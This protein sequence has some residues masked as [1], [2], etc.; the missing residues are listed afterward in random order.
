[1]RIGISASRETGRVQANARRPRELSDRGGSRPSSRWGG[2]GRAA[3][4]AATV[5]FA[6]S[7]SA[8]AGGTPAT[9]AG[10]LGARQ[11]LMPAGSTGTTSSGEFITNNQPGNPTPPGVP[12]NKWYSFFVEVPP[13]TARLRVQLFDPDHGSTNDVGTATTRYTLFDPSG[14]QQATALSTDAGP[15]AAN[16]AWWTL[17]DLAPA[18]YLLDQFTTVAYGNNNGPV[19]F[20]TNWIETSDDAAAATGGIFV[21]TGELRFGALP[22][23][24]FLDQFGVQAY[25]NSNGT[26][27]WAP[28]W[29]EANDGGTGATAGMIQV[30]SPGGQ[31][32]IRNGLFQDLFSTQVYT[33]QDGT[34]NWSTN[35]TETNDD[36][37]A[38]TGKVNVTAGGQLQ[39]RNG[40][41]Q[42]QFT[43]QA[44]NRQDGSLNWST[45]WTETND[46]GAAN[47]GRILITTA[48][49]NPTQLRLNG[50]GTTNDTSIA[51]SV[52]LSGFSTATLA[53]SYTTSGNLEA[54]DQ[55]SVDV[56]NG[57]TWNL[58]VVTYTND[59]TGTASIDLTPYLNSATQIRFRV[60]GNTY[61]GTT[62]GG[63]PNEFFYVDN[64]QI[65]GTPTTSAGI[66][67]GA[68]LSALAD[69]TLR[70][71]I[72]GKTNVTASDS[73][74]AQY[75]TDGGA[76]WSTLGTILGSVTTPAPFSY[77]LSP[78]SANARVR[79]IRTAGFAG[80][81]ATGQQ[82]MLIDD[83][84]ISGAP[85]A[86][87]DRGVDLSPYSGAALS[88]TVNGANVGGSDSIAVQY[89]SNGGSSWTDL[90]VISGSA[91][92]PASPTYTL[93]PLT[94]GSRVRFVPRSGLS[95]L[96]GPTEQ[97]FFVDDVRITVL[98]STI[99]SFS[100][101]R[102]A[103]LSAFATA[104]LTFDIRGENLGAGDTV[105]VEYSTNGGTNWTDLA[106]LSGGSFLL[107]PSYSITPSA[108]ARIRFSRRSGF[109][110]PNKAAFIDNVLI[111]Q[112]AAGLPV[113]GH[114]EV[115]IDMSSTVTPAGS[116][117]NGVGVRA[118]DGDESSG[119]R[120]LNVYY[121]SFFN[122]GTGT[123][124]RSW[125]AYPWMTSGCSCSAN[126]FDAVDQPFTVQL[127]TRLGSLVLNRPN[128]GGVVNNRW[129][130]ASTTNAFPNPY[131]ATGYGLWQ[132]DVTAGAAANYVPL[133]IGTFAKGPQLN[134]V[135]QPE[136]DTFR[137]YLPTDAGTKPLKPFLEQEV[138]YLG[139]PAGPNP[140]QANQTSHFVVTVRLVNPTPYPITLS[141]VTGGPE[142]VT[143]NVPGGVVVYGG[144]VQVSQGAVQTPSVGSGG[145]VVW[146]PGVVSA[147]NGPAE[148]D[149]TY[150]L[151][152]YQVR[153]TPPAV[154]AAS[155]DVTGTPT[156]SGTTATYFD[157][158]GNTTQTAQTRNT[159]GPLC[160]L[161]VPT[162]AAT[163]VLVE[164]VR[165]RPVG[166]SWSVEWT[167][168]SEAGTVGFEIYRR[169]GVA[170]TKAFEEKKI[171]AGM[172]P[173]LM[174]P[175]GGTYRV[176]DSSLGKT[177][178]ETYT[179]VE[180]DSTGG[181]RVHGP[182]EVKAEAQ[183]APPLP[184]SG[185]EKVAR[186]TTMPRVV[187]KGGPGGVTSAV[188]AKVETE[189]EGIFRITAASL[190]GP[191][192]M[193]E[194]EIQ[195][196]ILAR[197]LSVTKDGQAVSWSP[198]PGGGALQ[199]FAES[200]DSIYT[201]RNFY[202]ISGGA[203]EPMPDATFTAA[204]QPAAQQSFGA[205]AVAEKDLIDVLVL[206]LDPT[207][208]YW[209]WD[210]LTAGL[211]GQ[212]RKSFDVG[213]PGL[214]VGSAGTIEVEL[215]G[216]T[217]T[218]HHVRVAVNGS[219]VG[220]T[221]WSGIAR[222]VAQLPV[223]VGV[224]KDG[225]N[226]VELTALLD[227]GVAESAMFVDSFRVQHQR[228][229]RAGTASF[230][231]AAAG[232]G[233]VIVTALPGPDVQLFDVA[234][235]K[236]PR[237]YRDFKVGEDGAGG[238]QIVF[239]PPDGG[240]QFL[241]VTGAGLKT[242]S[243]V[244]A[245][246]SV[247][248]KTGGTHGDY[249][250]VTS[251][252]L[253]GEA[254]RLAARR[255]GQGLDPVVVT[256]EAIY[257]EFGDG[258]ASP[259]VLRAFF[260]WT[261]ASWSPAPKYVVLAGW[262]TYDY[263]DLLGYGGNHVPARMESTAGGL[264]PSDNG[265]VTSEGEE[266]PWAAI[267]RIPA[268]TLAEMTAYVDKVIAYEG[269]ASPGWESQAELIADN[270]E[271]GIDFGTD[272]DAHGGRLPPGFVTREKAYLGPM[273]LATARATVLGALNQGRG[274]VAYLGHGGME[275][276]AG[277]GILR[278]T[279]VAGLTPTEG[280]PV[281]TALTCM[282]NRYG[283]PGYLSLGE[284]LVTRA[285]AGTVATWSPTG[286]SEHGYAN[287]LGDQLVQ[288]LWQDQAVRL[289]DG[290]LAALIEFPGLGGL[291]EMTRLY[292]L[293][294]DPALVVHQPPDPPQPGGGGDDLAAGVKQ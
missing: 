3:V 253:L 44:Y 140:P 281:L 101:E 9:P 293:L 169:V 214:L 151:L 125:V 96:A 80:V 229:Y 173:A 257:D 126:V 111:V 292:T 107:S 76:N 28:T 139:G 141:S 87:I 16:N 72:T 252:E 198:A 13:G 43:T 24:T 177:E 38:T 130:R 108:N 48:A 178:G 227:A 106:V 206:P 220:E 154:P 127:R 159:L 109:N 189:G 210:S 272:M 119:G 147:A 263:K 93:S 248:L 34:L 51:R 275:R 224:L 233:M 221:T 32:Q 15:A 41:Y 88:F 25:N 170:G 123:G 247:G 235:P 10:P 40:F 258:M 204:G 243:R 179:I 95:G 63:T 261:R 115:R 212:D 271:A 175:T 187:G 207:G 256:D 265:Y 287:V 11:L 132:M 58:G 208:D 128:P 155:Y 54:A 192:G 118:D 83:V 100:I 105:A 167:T 62:G 239:Y 70:F 82:S 162:T 286:L 202:W 33:R 17:Y 241:A 1:M 230:A 168:A 236:H 6:W 84:Q 113:A 165:L 216:V 288:R 203:G 197:T 60:L 215:L 27:A 57:A 194:K 110:Q 8:L 234:D 232:T 193:S 117:Q 23:G 153:V 22:A 122:Y 61:T 246:Q 209:F 245:D 277:E 2:R 284:T 37:S 280:T 85:T 56:F 181:R 137:V 47:A 97:S 71:T 149:W 36:G 29:I 160:Q 4:V 211:T 213:V 21:S 20:T 66:S 14:A 73:I 89:S 129:D 81:T 136:A 270:P 143:V 188:R 217:S 18:S 278:L 39:I 45:D 267:G 259:E 176:L 91:T 156:A 146:A 260:E 75:S 77:P 5:A 264:Y 144:G 148:A 268:R 285:G 240:S 186:A 185:V 180:V 7:G 67:R 182:Y 99:P 158:T 64:V 50:F 74:A 174:R 152:T 231:F 138:R 92:L 78:L 289:G 121:H 279:D 79:F 145:S 205:T 86:T 35:W 222:H 244:V 103:D 219:I 112:S 46:D 135:F 133:Y 201:K 184:P 200:V 183:D 134:P 26:L 42:D 251:T 269:A 98:P 52:D 163:P 172:L 191:L 120:E 282:I 294:G 69:A 218:A 223:P 94:T 31:L 124:A 166:R 116:G 255:Q 226:T 164:E 68:D 291:S 199:I 225:T 157:E 12:L 242:P 65:Y 196:R 102:G 262:G 53:Y 290:V 171:H 30:T 276:L 150:E 254:Q 237:Q 273:D 131:D 238:W 249:L 19:S 274:Y 55:V 195:T 59:Q 49:P 161:S 90:G 266:A 142:V 190:A 228:S 114:W 283:I 104:T 250:V